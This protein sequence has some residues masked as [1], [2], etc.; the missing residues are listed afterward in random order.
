MRDIAVSFEIFPPKTSAGLG[1]L[2]EICRDLN[3]LNPD[4]FSVTFGAGGSSQLKTQC[5]VEQLVREKMPAVPHISCIH[6]TKE[7][8][9]ELLTK[10]I[11]LGIKRLFVLRGDFTEEYHQ[12]AAEFKY[13]NELVECIRLLTG[14]YFHISVAAYP[15]F[16]PEAKNFAEDLINFKRKVVAGANCAV[17]QFFFNTDA[18]FRFKE[19]CKK[20]GIH[21]PIIP[22]I[23]PITHYPK[24]LRFANICGAEIP[25]WL[26]RRLEGFVG[27]ASSL[28]TFGVEVISTLCEKLLSEGV[29]AL[30]FYTLNNVYPTKLIYHNLFSEKN[31]EKTVDPI[32]PS[33]RPSHVKISEAT[34][35]TIRCQFVL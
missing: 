1:N 33:K 17:T 20:V 5:V 8:L 11:K 32:P 21:I 6:M 31:R 27:D 4:Y 26:R 13:A 34:L 16:H 9:N 35:A 22:G 10:Y 30:H 15:E 28:K 18:Y 23:M 14:D 19:S 24:L 25:L 29:D 3:A 2:S 7:R 12:E